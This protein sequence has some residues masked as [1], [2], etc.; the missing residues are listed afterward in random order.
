M[1][2]LG[3]DVYAINIFATYRCA[4]PG[5]D[6][7]PGLLRKIRFQLHMMTSSIG[8]IFRV[9]GHLCEDFTVPA[10]RPV[11]RSFAVFFDLRMYKRLS[12]K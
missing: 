8:N 2:V 3:Q 10:Q 5:V 1:T 7:G 4:V 11:T 6:Q 12:N 9:T